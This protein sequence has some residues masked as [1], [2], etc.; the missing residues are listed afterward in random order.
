MVYCECLL[1]IESIVSS[2]G[3]R[4]VDQLALGSLIHSVLLSPPSRVRNLLEPCENGTS[5]VLPEKVSE[6]DFFS[7]RKELAK[8]M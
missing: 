6:K 7:F 8:R 5:F 1:G 3:L 4:S 2:D